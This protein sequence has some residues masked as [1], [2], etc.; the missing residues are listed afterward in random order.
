MGCSGS[1]ENKKKTVSYGSS[2][3][4][5]IGGS[6]PVEIGEALPSHR[7][8][9]TLPLQDAVPELVVAA[10]EAH[11]VNCPIDETRRCH[12]LCDNTLA[13]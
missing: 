3:I 6:T 7:D 1:F 2:P 13:W 9:R 5:G 10:Q 11:A 12:R 8:P 4:I